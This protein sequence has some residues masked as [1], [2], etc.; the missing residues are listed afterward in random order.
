MVVV[1]FGLCLQIPVHF[2]WTV[3]SDV[4]FVV[5]VM[6]GVVMLLALNAYV[7]LPILVLLVHP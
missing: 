1:V 5:V 3:Q 6:S 2:H 7:W 4:F